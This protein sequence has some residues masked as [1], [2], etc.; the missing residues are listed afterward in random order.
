MNLPPHR[1]RG[2]HGNPT[3][4]TR[5][6]GSSFDRFYFL[7]TSAKLSIQQRVWCWV[8]LDFTVLIALSAIADL[9]S[10]SEKKCWIPLDF[11]NFLK[12]H[13]LWFALFIIPQLFAMSN[14]YALQGSRHLV[15]FA[16]EWSTLIGKRCRWLV[17]GNRFRRSASRT[18]SYRRYLLPMYLGYHDFMSSECSN[19]SFRPMNCRF[20]VWATIS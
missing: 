15:P 16:W 20:L 6:D 10:F 11:N 5:A 3:G 9:L 19:D 8:M 14:S 13:A 4:N 7:V 12:D 18:A 1:R 17:K 2:D